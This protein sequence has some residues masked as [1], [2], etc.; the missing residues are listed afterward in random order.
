[1]NVIEIT[2]PRVRWASAESL[3]AL[4]DQLEEWLANSHLSEQ[5]LCQFKCTGTNP[6]G[7]SPA[8]CQAE[9]GRHSARIAEPA[10]CFGA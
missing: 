2:T 6:P 7:R 1:M 4:G 10:L 8:N 9:N 3:P 5:Q